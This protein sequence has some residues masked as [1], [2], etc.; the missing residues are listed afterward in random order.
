MSTSETNGIIILI[1]NLSIKYSI[2]IVE[3]DMDVIYELADRIY[4]LDR[5]S[6]I[7]EGDAK[8]VK[9]SKLVQKI[10]LGI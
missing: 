10:Y 4:V 5:G 1:K 8:S 2:I 7:F 3:H 9:E 6:L